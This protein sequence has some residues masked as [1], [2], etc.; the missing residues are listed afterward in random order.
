MSETISVHN[1]FSPGLSLEFSCI[2]L[3]CNS[4]N[5]LPSYC[6]L[7][8][9]KIRASDKDLPVHICETI[10]H[11]NKEGN[12]VNARLHKA[13]V[14]CEGHSP[15]EKISNHFTPLVAQVCRSRCMTKGQVCVK[16]DY[17]PVWSHSDHICAFMADRSSLLYVVCF[18]MVSKSL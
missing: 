10:L 15:S 12:L 17:A 9:A 7:V 11:K 2:E 18:T 13:E 4:M 8:D 14:F 5:N 16:F 6:G 1:M 3:V